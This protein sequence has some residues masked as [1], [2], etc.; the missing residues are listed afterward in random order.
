MD[1]KTTTNKNL[2]LLFH[3][4]PIWKLF[5]LSGLPNIKLLFIIFLSILVAFF[6]GLFI[7]LLAP[8]T[9]SILNS[10]QLNTNKFG[11]ISQFINTPFLLIGLLIISLFMKS[12]LNTYTNYYASR[13]KLIIR[14]RL[15]IKLIESVLNTSWK[16]KLEGGKLIDA[17]I[18]SSNKATNTIVMFTAILTNFL[19]VIAILITFLF[20]VSAQFM[21]IFL[22]L[23]FFYYFLIN[24]L[25]KKAKNLSF[26]ILN[27]KQDLSKI[28]SEV[29][30][31]KREL[32]IYGFKNI[33][34]NQINDS[35][36]ILVNKESFSAF[37]TSFPSIL[38]SLLITAIIVYGY[39][40]GAANNFDS[41]APIIV[42]SLVAVQRLGIYLSLIGQKLTAIRLG[43]AEIDYLLKATNTITPVENKKISFYNFY[44][45][46]SLKINNLTFNYGEG[47][48]LLKDLNLIFKSGKVS[49]ILGPSGSGKSSLLSLLLKESP[50]LSGSIEINNILL[51]DL[52]KDE[53]Y[54]YIS[55]VPQSPFIFGNT[56]LNNIKVGN[57]NASFSQITQAAAQS[58]AMEFIDNLQNKF[59]FYVDDGGSNLSGGQCQ[60]ISLTR[61]I[62]K[63]SPI[64]FLDEPSNNLDKKSVSNLKQILSFWAS[65][66]KLV[67]VI[68]HD[69]RLLDNDFDIY[70]I[71]NHNLIKQ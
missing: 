58:G 55:L 69:Q 32:Q 71:F 60:L 43:S 29:I 8:F 70:K 25:S 42:T 65:K 30:R 66:N 1:N 45:S 23:G 57:S 15:R 22:V 38:P 54:K 52:L 19:Y 46:N 4:Y 59:D 26:N 20:N 68:T 56:I 5:K 37:L 6:E 33:I 21:I 3:F 36:N 12:C 2:F 35:E 39:S 53:W 64:I 51:E 63:D 41:S 27:I 16:N 47:E 61:A 31:G 50:P 34:I 24:S 10:N 11:I 49:M 28:V 67:I 7:Y 48:E 9:N 44:S 14:K 18:N 40:Y 13:I 17:Y 62:I